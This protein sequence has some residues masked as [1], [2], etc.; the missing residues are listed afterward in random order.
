[1]LNVWTIICFCLAVLLSANQALANEDIPQY[2]RY[3]AQ[4]DLN[5]ECLKLFLDRGYWYR[6]GYQAPHI[7]SRVGVFAV[8]EF[9][10]KFYCAW[11]RKSLFGSIGDAQKK[12]IWD[13]EAV[14]APGGT[15]CEIYAYDNR[16]VYKN[17]HDKLD[18]A[19]KLLDSGDVSASGHLMAFVD[20]G[21]LSPG[22]KGRYYYLSGM[23]Q[24]DPE[25]VGNKAGLSDVIRDFHRAWFSYG[26]LDAAVEEGNLLLSKGLIDKDG[27][28]IRDAW[29]YFLKH[30]TDEQKRLYPEVEQDLKVIE[31]SDQAGLAGRAKASPSARHAGKPVH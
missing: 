30:A 19:M 4:Q 20:V 11:A 18:Y 31:L 2:V 12:A 17:N 15:P 26:N 6:P 3:R 8:G 22:D 21:S 9:H 13:C 28:Y 1:M 29:L 23:L 7:P 16:I 25:R 14:R 10:S 5:G 24:Y 27:Q